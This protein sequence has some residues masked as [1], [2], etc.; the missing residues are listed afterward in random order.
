[1]RT[2]LSFCYLFIL[3]SFIS[4]GENSQKKGEDHTAESEQKT[5]KTIPSQNTK[6]ILFYGN[7]LTA[8]MGLDPNEAFPALIQEKMD[9]LGLQY[10]VINAGLSGETSASGKNRIS[11]VL[12]QKV[13]VFVLELGANDGLRGIPLA[14]TKKNLQDIIDIVKTEN[15]DT[16]I[17]LAGMQIPPNMGPEYT[18]E[19]KNIFP[20][21]ASQNNL[22]L[23]P[24]LLENVAG[25]PE[26][27]QPDGI[28]PTAEGQRIIAQNIWPVIHEA[29]SH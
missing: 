10:K 17:I 20:K 25:I 14:E 6:V 11:W 21:L 29:I 13:D 24:F 2:L 22:I 7:S 15:P 18:S 26:L 16:V 9:T 28:H 4:C 5:T 27:N 19:F 3:I 1:M 8:G 12:K 23:I